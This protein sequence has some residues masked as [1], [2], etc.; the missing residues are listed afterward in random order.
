MNPVDSE[1]PIESTEASAG[2]ELREWDATSYHKVANPHVN[3]GRAVVDRVPLRGTADE[4]VIDVGCGTGRLTELLLERWPEARVIAVDQSA[5][6]LAEAKSFLAPR[7]DERV[8]FRQANALT[9]GLEEDA[10]A[11]FSTATF[12]WV[13]DHPAL[14]SALFRALRPGGWLIAQCGGGANI[15]RINHRAMALLRTPP[16]AAYIGEW[17]GPW[18]FA[19]AATTEDRLRAARFT[20]VSAETFSAPVTME[21]ADAYREFLTTVVFGTHLNRLPDDALRRQFI[22]LLVEA[23]TK[24]DPAFGLDYWRLNLQGQRPG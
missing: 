3:W 15:A 1:N 8:T 17:P 5:N 13:T 6:M 7:F 22:E 14:F 9:L 23:G 4:T 24:D 20:N 21:D 10:D 16:F 2:T 11:I 12:H 18:H 19:D